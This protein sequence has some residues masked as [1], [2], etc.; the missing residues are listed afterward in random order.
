MNDCFNQVPSTL[1]SFSEKARGYQQFRLHNTVL[2]YNKTHPGVLYRASQ[3]EPAIHPPEGIKPADTVGTT[4][5]LPYSS[6]DG[7]QCQVC[8]C[9]CVL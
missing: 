3:M 6:T 2:F 8:I 9:A 7:S 5:A 4:A 1:A